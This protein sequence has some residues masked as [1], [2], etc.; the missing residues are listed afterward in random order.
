LPFAPRQEAALLGRGARSGIGIGL[1]ET[2]GLV[3]DGGRGGLD[4]PP[5]ILARLA[6]PPEWRIVL[7]F[8]E[9]RRGVHGPDEVKAFRELPPFPQEAAAR[10]CHLVLMQ[11]LPAVAEADLPLF[12]AAIAE[13]QLR[14]GE[15]FAPAQG[16]V[17]TSPVVQAAVSFLAAH[18]GHGAGQSSWGPTGFVFVRSAEA[19]AELTAAFAR[20][21][22]LADVRLDV[23]QARNE[24]VLIE[25]TAATARGDASAQ[26][27]HHHRR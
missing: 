5:P 27:L 24:G 14:L 7:V 17:F 2:G 10:L 18:G 9:G 23:V 11:V 25:T 13:I 16:G 8:D 19:A 21:R 26:R 22:R 15:Y 20:E 1:F 3:V 12:G 4:A 6:F